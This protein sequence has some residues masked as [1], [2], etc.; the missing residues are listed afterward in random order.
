[1]GYRGFI[2]CSV[3]NGYL[4]EV[5]SSEVKAMYEGV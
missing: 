5:Q 2:Y 3:P 4:A 1:M